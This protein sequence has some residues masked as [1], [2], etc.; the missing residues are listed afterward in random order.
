MDPVEAGIACGSDTAHLSIFGYD[1][2]IYY[3]GRGAFESMGTGLDMH[4]GDIAFKCNF[5]V[6]DTPTGIVTCRRA[7]RHFEKEGPILS[8]YLNGTTITVNGNVYSAFVQ[9]ATEHR[10]GVCIRGP[11]LSDSITGTDPL[12]DNLPLKISEPLFDDAYLTYNVLNQIS[13]EF[14]RLLSVHPINQERIQNGKPP[15]NIV[16]FRGPGALPVYPS[17]NHTHQMKAFMITSTCIIAGIGRALQMDL[18]LRDL[19]ESLDELKI[20]FLEAKRLLSQDYDF[21]FVHIKDAD[22]ASHNAEPL[23]KVKMLEYVD[24]SLGNVISFCKQRDIAIVVTGDHTTPSSV[25]H[26]HTHHPVP[27]VLYK[28]SDHTYEHENTFD[29]LSCANGFLGRFSGASIMNLIKKF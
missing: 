17:F 22:E 21:G 9:Y 6:L 16:L 7:D 23:E 13:A 20:K 14:H 4:P 26:D 5:A 27:F 25:H 1:P 15:A 2:R 10:C 18:I 24:I 19:G 29:E 11:G 8:E 12:K 28:P 3:K